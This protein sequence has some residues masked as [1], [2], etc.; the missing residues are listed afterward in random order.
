[1]PWFL[2][3]AGLVRGWHHRGSSARCRS[4]GEICFFEDHRPLEHHLNLTT[5]FDIYVGS[6]REQRYEPDR[7]QT[8]ANSA[9]PAGQRMS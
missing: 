9:K 5:R 2:K 8:R 7:S 1:M 4:F 3:A 6:P